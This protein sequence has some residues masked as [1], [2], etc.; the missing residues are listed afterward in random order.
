MSWFTGAS[1]ALEQVLV[2]QEAKK[3]QAF[4]DA[5]KKQEQDRQFD[6]DN[7]REQR[8]ASDSQR[9]FDGL[10]F[11]REAKRVDV[12]VDDDMPGDVLDDAA[13]ALRKKHG[14]G[15]TF[16]TDT[17]DKVKLIV[18]PDGVAPGV[19]AGQQAEQAALPDQITTNVARG[20]A[21][22]VDAEKRR[23]AEIA[24]VREVEGGKRDR[25]AELIASRE[26]MEAA[27]NRLQAQLAGASLAGRVEIAKM[28]Q[29]NKIE[30]AKV[31]AE[32]REKPKTPEQL[33]AEAEA[34]KAG[35]LN[36]IANDAE[37]YEA[38]RPRRFWESAYVPPAPRQV[39]GSAR[40]TNATPQAPAGGQA[41][42]AAK[43]AAELIKKY[44][45]G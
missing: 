16:Q 12:A 18:G 39:G 35:E 5:L 17:R 1:D 13:A 25:Q 24:R 23:E 37:N 20:G 38:T 31:V 2:E 26:A 11:D 29:A 4:L 19:T 3:R 33:G 28:M 45:G 14:R 27:N 8:M 21:R 32:L 15:G 10:D 40:P 30:L 41:D 43:R 42:A 9:N 36:A 7:R 22:W 6:L 44:G 34:K